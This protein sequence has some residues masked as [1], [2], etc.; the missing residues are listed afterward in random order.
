[1]RREYPL[2]IEGSRKVYPDFTILKMP[3]RKEVYLE[4]FGKLDDKEYADMAIFKL[5]SYERNGIY[6][7]INL[8]ITYETSKR[9]I[10]ARALDEMLRTIFCN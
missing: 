1:M 3:E 2:I 7:G 4:H 9:P 6:L 8:F 10:N 5:N